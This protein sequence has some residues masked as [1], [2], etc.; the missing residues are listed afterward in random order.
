MAHASEH[1]RSGEIGHFPSRSDRIYCSADVW[2]FLIRGGQSMGPYTN[3]DE[4][5]LALKSYIH[6]LANLQ[7]VFHRPCEED[8]HMALQQKACTSH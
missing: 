4:A 2:H 8:H 1:H 7:I 5:K 6:T 3:V